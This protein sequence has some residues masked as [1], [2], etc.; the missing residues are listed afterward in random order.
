M[1]HGV[2][3]PQV[4]RGARSRISS[5]FRI[6]AFFATVISRAERLMP[7]LAAIIPNIPSKLTDRTKL[8]I[9]NS[10]SVKPARPIRGRTDRV[11]T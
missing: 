2:S 11:S 7:K 9:I 8:P 4:L 1:R 3:H 6:A 10:M 5:S